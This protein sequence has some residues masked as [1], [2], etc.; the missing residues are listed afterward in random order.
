MKTFTELNEHL[1]ELFMSNISL[2][3]MSTGDNEKWQYFNGKA[4]AYK[5]MIQYTNNIIKQYK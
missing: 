2:R 4:D 1:V 3:N 5:D